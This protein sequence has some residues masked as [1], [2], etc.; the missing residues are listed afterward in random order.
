MEIT[1]FKFFHGIYSLVQEHSVIK[2]CDVIGQCLD[3]RLKLE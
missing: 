3:S 1:V 2:Y